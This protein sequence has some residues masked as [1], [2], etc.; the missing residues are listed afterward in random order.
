MSSG[1]LYSTFKNPN[2]LC[3]ALAL[4]IQKY[5]DEKN[6]EGSSGT[7]ALSG[8]NT[9]KLLFEQLGSSTFREAINWNSAHLF[10]VDEKMVPVSHPD[11]NFGNAQN[12][13][14]NYIPINR[15]NIHKIRGEGEPIPEANR[16]AEEIKKI[17]HCPEGALPSFDWILLGVGMDGHVASIYP[18]VEFEYA[19]ENICGVIRTPSQKSKIITL[20][21]DT[22]LNASRISFIVT[23]ADKA[24]I[25]DMILSNKKASENMPAAVISR[26]AASVE[27]LLDER[28]AGL[29]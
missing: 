1:S 7:I 28:A 18:G 12:L 25:V 22:I 3:F 6:D 17:T 29:L 19:K 21:L 16:Y 26:N 24:E 9:P 8:G 10:W 14:L 5:L 27:W 11:S 2:E 15:K 4:D 13:F 23:G 20:T